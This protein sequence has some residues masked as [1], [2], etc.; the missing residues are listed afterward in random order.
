MRQFQNLARLLGLAYRVFQSNRE[1]GSYHKYVQQLGADIIQRAKSYNDGSIPQRMFLK[2]QWYMVT[3]LF[4]GEM[5]ARLM[6]KRL[7]LNEQK[8]FLYLAPILGFSD[9]LIDDYKYSDEKMQELLKKKTPELGKTPIEKMFLLFYIEFHHLLPDLLFPQVT[10]Y[11]DKGRKIQSESLKQFEVNISEEEIRKIVLDKGGISVLLCRSIL[12]PMMNKEEEESFYQLGGLMQM[13]NDAVDLYKDGKEGI[14]STA[15]TKKTLKE[16]AENLD[17]Q[18]QLTF[19]L[20]KQLTFKEAHKADFLFGFYVFVISVFFKLK[21][22][23]QK[24]GRE[25]NYQQFLALDKKAARSEPFSLDSF[26]YCFPKILAF[27]YRKAE[28]AFD[29]S[30]DF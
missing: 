22:Y 19:S 14:R 18:K 28:K 1:N 13:M 29:F 21:E 15:N 4:M 7:N 26:F 3:H 6:D 17:R 24:C 5:F 27:D 12:L 30:I 20:L 9:I 10:A 8:R 2:M 11:L 23:R 16:V 25:Y